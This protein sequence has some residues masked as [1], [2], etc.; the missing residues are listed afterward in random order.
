MGGDGSGDDDVHDPVHDCSA[1][2]VLGQPCFPWIFIDFKIEF[3]NRMLATKIML[4]M[5]NAGIGAAASI[6]AVARSQYL[7]LI[8][9][10]TRLGCWAEVGGAFLP[11]TPSGPP[12]SR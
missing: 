10:V 2:K 8:L 12:S 5:S 9:E 11:S 7:C 3:Q 4:P 6:F 1:V